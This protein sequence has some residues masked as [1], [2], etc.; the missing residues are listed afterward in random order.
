METKPNYYTIDDVFNNVYNRQLSKTTIQKLCR[1]GKIP[2]ERFVHKIL[3]PA[4][5]VERQLE[6][7]Q[8]PQE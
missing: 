4:W 6:K 5:W 2:S 3:V 8:V 7:A 1:A